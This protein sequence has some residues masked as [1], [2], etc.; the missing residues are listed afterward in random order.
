MIKLGSLI[1]ILKWRKM[2]MKR[3]VLVFLVIVL[4]LSSGKFCLGQCININ[5]AKTI[6]SPKNDE[7][8]EISD[9]VYSGDYIEMYSKSGNF[10][11]AESKN[12]DDYIT[13]RSGVFNG[14][15]IAQGTSRV[16]WNVS[17]NGQY[18]VHYNSD[19]TCGHD[20]RKRDVTIKN[21]SIP[22]QEF[23]WP[24]LS[25]ANDLITSYYKVTAQLNTLEKNLDFLTFLRQ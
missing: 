17:E 22:P 25:Q 3:G 20:L 2:S 15:V 14:K 4:I 5:K 1:L 13:I 16:T 24:Y 10:F 23:F 11:V 19:R 9:L 8:V 12:P 18:Y 6:K 21:I 7:V